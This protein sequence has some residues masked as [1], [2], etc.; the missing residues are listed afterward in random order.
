MTASG[1][2]TYLGERVDL[3]Q[4]IPPFA[5]RV[6]LAG[7][8]RG[9]LALLLKRRGIP[10]V[11]AL[12]FESPVADAVRTICDSVVET[13]YD[14]E[15]LCFEPGYFDV[16]VFTRPV[17]YL[18]R[19]GA[20][21]ERLV[22]Y[23]CDDGYAMFVVPNRRHWSAP[24]VGSDPEDLGQRIAQAG[25]GV[26]WNVSAWDEQYKNACANQ[27]GIIVLGGRV[28]SAPTD[29]ACNDLIAT[30]HLILGVRPTYNPIVHARG[31]LNAGRPEW[32]Y[33][34]LSN[35]PKAYHENEHVR[36]TVSGDMMVCLLT[37]GPPGID[38]DT[39][40]RFVLSQQLFYQALAC[41]PL[42]HFFYQVQ[43]EFWHKIGNDDMALR[44]LR[45]ISH[46]APDMATRDQLGGYD[47]ANAPLPSSLAPPEWVRPEVPPRI[48]YILNP[49]THY[50]IDIL[51]DGLCAE[52]G[53]DRVTDFPWKPFLHGEKPDWLGNYPCACDW[54][55]ENLSVE[56]VIDRLKHGAFDI[57]LFGDLELSIGADTAKRILD[58]ASGIPL[59]VVD[60]LDDAHDTRPELA[61]H[62]G[63]PTFAGYFKREMLVGVDYGPDAF[64]L[65]FAYAERRTPDDIGGPRHTDLFWA[66]HRKFG[67]RRLYLER[68]ESL[69]G[70]PLQGEFTPEE[71]AQRLLD[72]QIGLNIFGFGY[73]TV[74][75]WE[76][77]A[78]GCMLLAER[79]PIHIPYNFVDGESAV[80]FD[81]LPDLEQKLAY[82]LAH[83]A[84]VETIARAGHEHFRRYHT[85]SP[86]ARQALGWMQ[87]AL[88]QA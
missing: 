72:A 83:P 85:A 18:D 15:G 70:Y 46:V 75:Y 65:P 59:F 27:D 61:M 74:R 1:E 71:Y 7:C 3:V 73:D 37:M 23:L 80:F 53:D 2:E 45:S 64:P 38:E 51:Y 16:I 5:Q 82:Y 6:L 79:M 49:R 39:I 20:I 63:N 69:L 35:I 33:D 4:R 36:A 76:L 55:G 43:A 87:Q 88:A 34:V 32:A 58:A 47:A 29:E 60:A 28:F 62:L 86:R 57:V 56:Q 14:C 24:A 26:Y 25:L 9:E 54:G 22:P 68:L 17:D 30:D 77:P 48:L 52:L 42:N 78:H 50:G 81:D 66:G 31:F 11:H 21:A 67:L 8:G 41:E 10:E 12:S 44:L 40:P 84:E 13:S 19:L